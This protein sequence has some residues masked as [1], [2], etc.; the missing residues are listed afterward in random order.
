MIEMLRS[1]TS[2]RNSVP[3]STGPDGLLV[4]DKPP[5]MTS[6][7]VVDHVRK[8]LHTKKVGHGG[9]L[10]PD[11]TGVLVVGVGKATRLLAYSQSAPKSYHGTA[12]FGVT[13]STQDAS[14]DVLQERDVSTTRGD[15]EAVLAEFVGDISQIPPMVSAVKVDGE[16]LYRKARRGEE[17]ERAARPVHVYSLTLES[18]TDGPRPQATFDVECSGGT[19]IRTLVNDIGARLGC[20][21][22]LTHLRRT[23]SGGFTLE[24]AIA[25]DDVSIEKMRPLVDVV[26][27][28]RRVEVDEEA[29]ASVSHGRRLEVVDDTADDEVV[30]V[31][32]GARLLAVYRRRGDALVA[33]RVVAT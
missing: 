4:I 19:Y 9:T 33:E 3:D 29:A 17:V 22:H 27:D 11:A 15:L 18:W 14:G 28:M 25:L 23:A 12:L 1:P 32:R 16:R 5:G 10:D 24:D 7:D 31:T 6:H 2:E 8:K 26:G 21:A 30:A 13:T 20:G